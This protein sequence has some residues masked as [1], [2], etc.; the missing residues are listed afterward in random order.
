RD[1]VGEEQCN[2]I[3]KKGNLR[4]RKMIKFLKPCYGENE[5]R[6]KK[7]VYYYEP[8]DLRGTSLLFLKPI[9]ESKDN[10]QLI[11]LPS[12]RRVRRAPPGQDMDSPSGM[13]LTFDQLD[14]NPGK[15][16]MDIIGEKTIYV[17]QP[18]INNCYGSEPHRAYMNAKHCVIVEMTPR[19][20]K[21]PVSRDVLYYDKA[22]AACYYEE[23]YNKEGTVER[24]ALHFMAHLYP[25]NPGYWT[26]GD[27][28]AH[29][30]IIDHKTLYGPPEV[31]R[32]GNKIFDYATRDWSNYLFWFDTGLSDEYFS[33]R[34]MIRGTR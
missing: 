1:W 16:D 30:L 23:I 14:R 28:Y 24:I 20:K 26:L 9:D 11:Y 25:K 32:T 33:E 34:F 17:D 31:D 19:N 27:V 4:T 6:F 15:W 22:S 8:Q 7:M 12:I 10:D 5:I 13:D 21:W 3:D 29:N 2:L 18:P